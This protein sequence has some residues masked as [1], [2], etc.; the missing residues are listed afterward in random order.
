MWSSTD[1]VYSLTVTILA[2]ARSLVV[3]LPMFICAVAAP[4]HAEHVEA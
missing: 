3:A 1:G 2:K 4:V